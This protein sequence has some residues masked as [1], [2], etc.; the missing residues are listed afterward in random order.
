MFKRN[1]IE[2]AIAL[3]LEPGSAKPSSEMRTQLRRLLE[4]DRGFG[5]NKRSTDPERANFAFYGM[6]APGRG[7]EN[8]FSHY[9]TFSLLL[10]LRLMRLDWPQGLVVA[11]L[12]RIRPELEKNHA[13][14]LKEEPA[15]VF[16]GQHRKQGKPGDIAVDNPNPLFLAISATDREDRSGSNPAAI[17]RGQDELMRFIKSQGVG[18]IWVVLEIGNSVRALSSALTRTSPRKRGRGSQ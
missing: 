16:D 6:D 18:Q 8:W 14:I 9:E 7:V 3:V 2:E 5:R 10:G 12:R 15:D 4:T 13:R 11:V 1:Q 17:C